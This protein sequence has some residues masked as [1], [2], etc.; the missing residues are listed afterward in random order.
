[1]SFPVVEVTAEDYPRVIVTRDRSN[2]DSKFYGPFVSAS[3]LRI[4]L[5]ILQRVFKYRT[6]NMEIKEGDPK[7]RHFRPCLEYHIGRCKAPCANLQGSEDYKAD[8]RRR[9]SRRTSRAT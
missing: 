5:Q 2:K 9:M 4:A 3:W 7:N 6:C 1:V 8:L